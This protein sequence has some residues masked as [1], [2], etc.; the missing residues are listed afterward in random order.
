MDAIMAIAKRHGL[1]VIEDAAH[2]HGSRWRGVNAGL[3]GDAGSFSMQSS[4]ILNSGE[5]GII[6]LKDEKQNILA[7]SARTCGRQITPGGPQLHSGNFRMTEFQSAIALCQL[8][9]LDEQSKTREKTAAYLETELAKIGGIDPLYRNPA[10]TFQ[11]YYCWSLCY[12]KEKWGGVKRHAFTRALSAELEGSFGFGSTYEP[13][14]NSIFYIPLNKRTHKLN[15]C[16]AAAA[17]PSRFDLP[18]ADK[19]YK[20]T[21]LNTGH[22][23]LLMSKA[24]AKKVIDAVAK[25]KKNLDELRDF[26]KTL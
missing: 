5:G 11:T 18:V 16:Y 3:T 26:A 2:Q 12:D 15:D 25:I 17:D 8:A 13:L 4:K 24:D 20:E 6:T 1:Y 23:S 7:R 21:A 14:N 19:V 10:I 9:R 22:S